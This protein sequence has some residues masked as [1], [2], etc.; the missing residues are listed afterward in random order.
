MGK[1]TLFVNF[2]SI[3]RGVSSR[4]VTLCVS[5][6]LSSVV[7][8]Y[9]EGGPWVAGGG[10]KKGSTPTLSSCWPMCQGVRSCR[11][12][13]GRLGVYMSRGTF[14]GLFNSVSTL[15]GHPSGG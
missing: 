10:T 4:F 8:V 13:Y 5:F 9:G 12:V 3:A 2:E 1:A 15:A 6:V 11:I 7:L 14:I